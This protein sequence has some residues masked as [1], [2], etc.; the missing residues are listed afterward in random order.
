MARDF[1]LGSSADGPCVKPHISCRLKAP[2][3]RAAS[4]R[5]AVGG[6]GRAFTA[7]VKEN[8]ASCCELE[9]CFRV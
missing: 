6:E 1:S 9:M 4:S 8:Q 5:G 3:R 7:Q 2:V